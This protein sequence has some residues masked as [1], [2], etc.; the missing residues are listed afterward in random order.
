MLFIPSHQEAPNID[1][2]Q[3]VTTNNGGDVP[4]VKD[5]I[6]LRKQKIE[7]LLKMIEPESWQENGGGGKITWVEEYL[8]VCN[9]IEVHESISGKF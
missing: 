5:S 3:T 1:L 7:V 8:V 2:R 4:I 9:T 6:Q